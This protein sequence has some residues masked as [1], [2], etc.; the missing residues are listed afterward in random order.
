MDSAVKNVKGILGK[1]PVFGICLGHQLL[2]RAIGG[3]TFKLK[4]GHRGP[5]QPVREEASGRVQITAQNHGYAV[6]L[7][8]PSVPVTITYRNLN[9]GTVEGIEIPSLQAFSAQH[10][11]EA[12]PGPHDASAL[13]DRFWRSVEASLDR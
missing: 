6:T 1:L 2:S 3:K 5:N 13:F 10:H 9:D 11:P 12:A 7:E 8:E 4:F